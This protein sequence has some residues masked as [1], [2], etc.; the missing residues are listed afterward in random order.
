EKP[1]LADMMASLYEYDIDFN[2]DL[3][4]KDSFA[5]LVEKMYLE[6]R[7]VRYGYILAAEFT[8][9][10]KTIRVVRYTEPEGRTAYF[11]PDGSSV[12]K[13]FLRCPLPF[14][15]VTSRYGRRR[16]PLLNFSTR[17]N[18]VDLAAAP[19]TKVRAT[20]SGIIKKIGYDRSKGRFI[21]I[22]HNNQYI[23]H[24]YHL[25]RTGKGIKPG[26]RVEQGQIIGCVGSTGWA[27]GSHLHYGIQKNGRFINPLSLKS[28]S[29]EPVKKIYLNTFKQYAHRVLLLLSGSK[30]VK[31]PGSVTETFL[32]D[33]T[34]KPLQPITL[35]ILR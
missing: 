29:K 10:G 5:L 8:N 18:G 20:A 31:I 12:R 4:E 6:G 33:S 30:W 21:C 19:G 14:M 11:H 22:R 32:K 2:R 24:Y 17:H 15:R 3:R 13:M 1:E 35:P 23:S 9:R 26:V 27:T 34:A 25:S 28:P 7:F 16:H